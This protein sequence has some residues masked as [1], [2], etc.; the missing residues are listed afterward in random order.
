MRA[1]ALLAVL[2]ALPPAPRAQETVPIR[3]FLESVKL[4][5]SLDTV[6]Q[7]YPPT[8]EWTRARELKGG[9]ERISIQRGQA[10][11]LPDAVESMTLGFRHGRLVR[12]EV[13]FGRDWTKKKPLERLVG[14]LALDYGEPRRSGESYFWWDSKTVLVAGR[15]LK[16]ASPDGEAASDKA[17]VRATL[18]VMD[19]A[20]FEP[21]R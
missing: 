1:A 2:A 7:V 11:Y 9:L 13:V 3:R 6:R 21:L 20:Y 4:G 15:L 8:K 14:D 10:K 16:P 19:R 12:L 5:D 17:E 18:A